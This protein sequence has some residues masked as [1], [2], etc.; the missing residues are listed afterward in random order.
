MV[1]L[2]FVGLD[3]DIYTLEDND[4]PIGG[5]QVNLSGTGPNGITINRQASTAVDGKFQF[6]DLPQGTYTVTATG[7][8]VEIGNN[9]SGDGSGSVETP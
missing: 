5:V 3:E 4:E 9:S 1:V 8:Q 6:T 7:L 2:I